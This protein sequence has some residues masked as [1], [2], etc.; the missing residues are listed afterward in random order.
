MKRLGRPA[1][2]RLG[3]Q[4][5]PYGFG[6][7]RMRNYTRKILTPNPGVGYD[8]S[9][10]ILYHPMNESAGGVAIDHS[11]EGND[12]AYAGVTLGQP[13][14]GDGLTCPFF[15]GVNS[16]NNIYSAALAADFDGTE[17]TFI[18]HTK[19]AA[20]TWTDG[21]LRRLLTIHADGQNNM[22][23]FRTANDNEF[24]FLYRANN[25]IE[26]VTIGGQS[27]TDFV[28]WGMTWSDDD[29][30]FKAYKNDAQ[31][32]VTQ[33]NLGTWVGPL[34][35]TDTVI[36]AFNTTADFEWLGYNAHAAL[37]AAALPPAS[38]AYLGVL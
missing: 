32:G 8:P 24:S 34:S 3:F 12:G 2:N 37:F 7:R 11:P 20:G 23:L 30:E 17:G 36:G 13:G 26:Q 25:I 9:S 16:I 15:P 28:I 14:I 29:E 21:T 10:L 6:S 19:I 31:V 38:M 18:I 4:S 1:F 33:V 27:D 5:L 35:A 22:G